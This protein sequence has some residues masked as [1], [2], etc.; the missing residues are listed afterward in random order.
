MKRFAL[1]CGAL[2]LPVLV[3]AAAEFEIGADQLQWKLT[4]YCTI[5]NRDGRQLLQIRVPKGAK[6]VSGQNCA[7]L[8]LDMKPFAGKGFHASVRVRGKD[9]SQPPQPY[10]GV[11]FMLYFKNAAGVEFWPDAEIPKGT[12]DWREAAVVED[13]PAGVTEGILRLGLQESSGEVEF[14]L[15]SCGSPLRASRRRSACR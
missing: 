3:M 5:V 9:V 8:K 1:F 2:L 11:K 4:R 7:Y 10:N 15:S 12:F 14:D 6:D 13:I